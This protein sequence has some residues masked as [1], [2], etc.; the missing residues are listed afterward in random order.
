MKIEFK[1]N[2]RDLVIWET[3]SKTIKKYLKYE[4]KN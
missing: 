4:S 1:Y 2:I 3:S